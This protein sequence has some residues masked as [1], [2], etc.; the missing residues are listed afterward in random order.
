MMQLPSPALPL[1]VSDDRNNIG[2]IV[3]VV[4]PDLCQ[5]FFAAWHG[6]WCICDV[7]VSMIDA[8]IRPIHHSLNGKRITPNKMDRLRMDRENYEAGVRIALSV[9]AD[10]TNVGVSFQDA[11]LAVY[12]SGLQ[13]GSALGGDA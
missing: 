2:Q 9:F 12:L 8:T 13:H 6:Y 11:I 5:L 1:E 3:D 4:V 10:C 7:G